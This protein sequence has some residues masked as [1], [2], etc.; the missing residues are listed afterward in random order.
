[1]KSLL[2]ALTACLSLVTAAPARNH[3]GGDRPPA[4]LYA[5]ADDGTPLHWYL[6]TPPGE[7]PAPLVILG[8]G[9]GF[10]AGAPGPGTV[11]QDLASQGYWVA[12]I[13]YRLAPPGLLDGQPP[14]SDPQS[15]RPPE[16]RDDF[17]AA[18]NAARKDPRFTAVYLVGGSAG[19][20]HSLSIAN[21][22]D[23]VV[24]LSPAA[25]FNAS[26]EN[27]QFVDDVRNYVNSSDPAM[28]AAVSPD[29][30]LSQ[31]GRISTPIYVIASQFEG[32]NGHRGMP[33]EQYQ[34]AVAT[35]QA[36]GD[37]FQSYLIKGSYLHAFDYW[38]MVRESV[39][40]FLA[41]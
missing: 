2:I 22:V 16:Q 34:S 5:V 40:A 14:H 29:T 10:R 4:Q 41:E 37:N 38:P 23:K 6:F 13:E 9:G 35:L 28:L 39:F 25:D 30:Y 7:R 8:H 24:A 36:M 31:M 21:M 33:P 1:M 3:R 27:Y 26:P 18:V 17:I 12:A 19:G 20:A 15:G 11:A 32:T